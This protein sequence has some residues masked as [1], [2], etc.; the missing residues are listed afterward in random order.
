MF[1]STIIF[2]YAGLKLWAHI[3]SKNVSIWTELPYLAGYI[4]YL[5]C[6]FY[7]P[8]KF[9]FYMKLNSACSFVITC[10][11]TRLIMKVHGFIRENIPKGVQRK[12][13]LS[14]GILVVN[15]GKT[16]SWPSV[17]QF[18]YYMFCPSFL[19]RDSYPR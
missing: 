19:Y 13:D 18:I 9:L 17:E 6:L 14:Q 15:P 12:L 2:P 4:A 7:F 5:M 11:N 16:Q 8:L 3:A 10:E 1:I